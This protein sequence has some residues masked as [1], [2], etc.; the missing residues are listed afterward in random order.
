MSL[1]IPRQIS[2]GDARKSAVYIRKDASSHEGY[3][4]KGIDFV[5]YVRNGSQ[6]PLI[7]K[8]LTPSLVHQCGTVVSW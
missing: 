4:M 1:C 8:S 5:M 3:S 7:M 2:E 6:V